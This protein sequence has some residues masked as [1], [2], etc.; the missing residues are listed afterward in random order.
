MCWVVVDEVVLREEL[1]DPVP[2][3]GERYLGALDSVGEAE[4]I[5]DDSANLVHSRCRDACPQ[6]R[7]GCRETRQQFAEASRSDMGRILVVQRQRQSQVGEPEQ[8]L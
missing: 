3:E 8:Y 2:P 4:N 1:V 5:V 6:E 7:L